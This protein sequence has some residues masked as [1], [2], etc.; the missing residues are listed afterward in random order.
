MTYVHDGKQYIVFA[1]GSGDGP[2]QLIAY[3]LSDEL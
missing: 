3:A 2:A 1:T